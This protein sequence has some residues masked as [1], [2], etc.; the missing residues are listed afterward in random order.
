[1]DHMDFPSPGHTLPS[2]YGRPR[3]QPDKVARVAL[4]SFL[5]L[6]LLTAFSPS[7]LPLSIQ[8]FCRDVLS[9][10]VFFDF[11]SDMANVEAIRRGGLASG[12][13]R[14][15]LVERKGAELGRKV[16]IGGE[17]LD[18]PF[19]GFASLGSCLVILLK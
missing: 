8:A 4:L 10:S 6:L 5:L 1:M 12:G 7:R 17:G 14:G 13:S 15:G 3:L 16:E 18:H 2:S 19:G 9:D 11:A